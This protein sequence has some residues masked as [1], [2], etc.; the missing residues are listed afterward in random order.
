MKW[1]GRGGG[2]RTHDLRLKSLRVATPVV[3]NQGVAFSLFGGIA[4]IWAVLG[5]LTY[6]FRTNLAFGPPAT[7]ASRFVSSHSLTS[8]RAV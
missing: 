5:R 8:C 7:V 2:D 3:R 1:F 4:V 6:F